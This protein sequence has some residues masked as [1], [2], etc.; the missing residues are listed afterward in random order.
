MNIYVKDISK[1]G[2]DHY[3]KALMTIPETRKEID[4]LTEAAKGIGAKGLANG[5]VEIKRRCDDKSKMQIVA[6]DAAVEAIKAALEG[7]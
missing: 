6:P 2:E 1:I 7:E 4:K 5:G 3:D